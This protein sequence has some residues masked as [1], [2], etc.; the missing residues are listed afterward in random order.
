MF[1]GLSAAL[2]VTLF[3]VQILGIETMD[4]VQ[5]VGGIILAI[6][7]VAIVG[8]FIVFGKLWMQA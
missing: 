8:F 3:P 5:I 1:Q 6:I 4:V 2:A 7:A